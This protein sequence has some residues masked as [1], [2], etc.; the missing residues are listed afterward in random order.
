MVRH[1]PDIL[2]EMT[3]ALAAMELDVFKADVTTTKQPVHGHTNI[4]D[5]QSERSDSHAELE[6]GTD[7]ISRGVSKQSNEKDG[8]ERHTAAA[9]LE[10]AVFYQLEE[11]E[12]AIFYAR[13]ADGTHQFSATRRAEIK[14]AFDN[15]S[16]AHG[17]HGTILLRVVHES[18]MSIAHKLPKF[19]HEERVVSVKCTGDHHKELL[20]EICDVLHAAKLDVIHAEM[21][22]NAQGLEEHVL[23]TTRDRRH[24]SSA[25]RFGRIST[26]CTGNMKSQTLSRIPTAMTDCSSHA[27]EDRSDIEA[28]TM[29]YQAPTAQRLPR[30]PGL[31]RQ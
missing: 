29:T 27:S 16:H 13:E 14:G 26:T 24:S 15:L 11:K 28:P 2:H 23:Y 30:V 12:R 6:E 9:T 1:H 10:G 8:L 31:I 3:D 7:G 22:T 19:D 4:G 25:R 17:V 18:Q 5:A 20:H 21:D